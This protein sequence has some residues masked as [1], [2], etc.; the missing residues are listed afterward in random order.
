MFLVKIILW[1]LIAVIF[2]VLLDKIFIKGEY[3][4]DW[5]TEHGEYKVRIERVRTFRAPFCKPKSRIPQGTKCSP[6]ESRMPSWSGALM[7]ERER[8][9]RRNW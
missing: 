9:S 3:E 7:V 6:N 4:S 8:K 1:G 2:Y 5:K